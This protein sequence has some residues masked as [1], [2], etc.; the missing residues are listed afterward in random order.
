VAGTVVAVRQ[1][2]RTPFSQAR[3][4]AAWL[5]SAYGAGGG[6]VFVGDRAPQV[7]SVVSYLQLDRIYYADRGA[8]GSYVVWDAA[9]TRHRGLGEAIAALGRAGA[10]D[11]VLV[12]SYPVPGSLGIPE[13]A[14]VASFTEPAVS[15]EV[16][17]IYRVALAAGPDGRPVLSAATVR[18]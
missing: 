2:W 4:A 3:A 8:F 14:R 16:Y 18:W 7:S 17:Y 15:G 9:R 10:R 13:S 5:R 12:L 6:M 1:D 11:I